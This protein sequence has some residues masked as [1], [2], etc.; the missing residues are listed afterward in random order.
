MNGAR[1]GWLAL[2]GAIAVLFAA[3]NQEGTITNKQLVPMRQ[4][5]KRLAQD[6]DQVLAERNDARDLANERESWASQL[7]AGLTAADHDIRQLKAE[8]DALRHE[9]AKLSLDR[10]QLQQTV[11]SLQQER[12]QTKRNL[13]QLRHGL[14]QLL[15]QADTATATLAQPA[16]GL[17]QTTFEKPVATPVRTPASLPVVA[18]TYQDVPLNDNQ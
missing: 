15:S 9:L 7:E 16:Q 18:T 17:S 8:R 4:E 2:I 5:V 11:L 14:H 1:W 3:S 12:V 13:E 6:R 10:G